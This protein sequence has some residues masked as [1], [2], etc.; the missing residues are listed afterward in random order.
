MNIA[1]LVKYEVSVK[2]M[3]GREG[4]RLNKVFSQVYPTSCIHGD[5]EGGRTSVEAYTAI[6]RTNAQF[7]VI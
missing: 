1:R 3:V 2:G 6:N 7:I 5:E 4:E